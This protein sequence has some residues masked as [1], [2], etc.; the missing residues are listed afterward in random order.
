AVAPVADRPRQKL[1]FDHPAPASG[2]DDSGAARLEFLFQIAVEQIRGLVTVS[3]S[4]DD[5]FML[6]GY[7]FSDAISFCTSASSVRSAICVSGI[8]FS[9]FARVTASSSATVSAASVMA[10]FGL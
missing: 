5:H 2:V 8:F 9:I 10:P 3:V 7:F 4:V 6:L 1:A